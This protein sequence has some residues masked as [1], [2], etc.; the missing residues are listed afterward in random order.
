MLGKEN[1]NFRILENKILRD[2]AEASRVKIID[3]PR[4]FYAVQFNSLEDY[5]NVLY[6]GP[7]MVVDH[8]ILV[9]RWRPNFLNSAK[10]V[11]KVAVWVRIPELPLELYNDK[12]LTR[13][14]ATMGKL[15]KVDRLT[16]FQHRGQFARICV[17]LDLSKPLVPQVVV[18]GVPLKLV[19]EGLHAICFSCGV[20]GHRMGS[21][22]SK[23]ANLLSPG[24]AAVGSSEVSSLSALQASPVVLSNVSD[25]R[26]DN[27]E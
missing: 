7:W 26:V 10:T 16:S 14:G 3:M 5:N 13:L 11:S 6:K 12:F 4:G 18:R 15:L 25:P 22:S 23:E 20:Y 17:E 21:C 2:W 8:Y 19:Y 24:S 1:L 9:Q 27:Q